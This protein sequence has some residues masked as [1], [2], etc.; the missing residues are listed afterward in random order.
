MCIPEWLL[1]SSLVKD[2]LIGEALETCL[3]TG[4]DPEMSPL[5]GEAPETSLLIPEGLLVSFHVCVCS[6]TS[7]VAV[8]FD[9]GQ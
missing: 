4:E 8:V 5:I 6:C 3:L 1:K 2:P 9:N 7:S